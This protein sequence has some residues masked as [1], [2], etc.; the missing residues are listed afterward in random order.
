MLT[1]EEGIRDSREEIN[2]SMTDSIVEGSRIQEITH[3]LRKDACLF[4]SELLLNVLLGGKLKKKQSE[5]EVCHSEVHE[6][7]KGVPLP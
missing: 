1:F 5:N 7:L 6:N 2:P 4:V 3:E